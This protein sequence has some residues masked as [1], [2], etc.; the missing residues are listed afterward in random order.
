MSPADLAE[1]KRALGEL[2]PA[3]GSVDVR[4]LEGVVVDPN[5][6]FSIKVE[7]AWLAGPIVVRAATAEAAGEL[8]RQAMAEARGNA[9]RVSF[10]WPPRGPLE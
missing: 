3:G 4:V 9:E 1:H 6:P 2:L 10:T 5:A 7:L 8:M